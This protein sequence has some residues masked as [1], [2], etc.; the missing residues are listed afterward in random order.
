MLS[1]QLKQPYFFAFFCLVT[2]STFISVL[3]PLQKAE[4]VTASDWRAGRIIDDA[5]FYN[6]DSMSVAQIQD[7]LNAKVPTCDRWR[8]SS[9]P[10]YQ[11]PWT[12]LKEYLENPTTRENNVGRFNANGTPY[13]VPGGKSAAQI[14]WDVGQEYGINPQVLIVMLQK[15][16][17]LITDNWPWAVQYQ[18]AMGYA[19]PDTAPCDIQYYG[20]YNQVSSAAWQMKRYIAYPNSYNFKAGVTRNILWSPNAS[21]GASP[22]YIE[23]AATAALYNYTPYQPNAAALNNLYGTGDGCSAYGNRN[24]WRYFNDWFGSGKMPPAVQSINGGPIYLYMTGYRVEVTQMAI[25]QDYGISPESIAR[26]D[27]SIISSM[28]SP[29]TDGVSGQLG[30]IIKSTSD[31]DE[32]G[33]SIYFI[34]VGKKYQIKSMDQFFNFG[35]KE[36][37]IKYYP[38]SYINTISSAGYLSDFVSTPIYNVFK[39]SNGNKRLIFTYDDYVYYNPSKSATNISYFTMNRFT[40]GQPLVSKPALIKPDVGDT[41]FL[42]NQDAY[43]TIP[44]FDVYN[45]WGFEGNLNIPVYRVPSSSLVAQIQPTQT[46]QCLTRINNNPVLLNKYYAIPTGEANLGQE[47]Q[48]YVQLSNL[49]SRITI[50]QNGIKQ[51]VKKYDESLVW[52]LINGTKKAIPTYESFKLMGLTPNTVDVIYGDLLNT[53]PSG[54]PMLA[55]GQLV[56]T[57]SNSAV[58]VVFNDRRFIYPTSD[59]FISYGNNWNNIATI[60]NTILDTHYPVNN[61]SSIESMFYDSLSNNIYSITG[62]SCSILDDNLLDNLGINRSS[63]VA[64]Q[65]VNKTAFPYLDLNKCKPSSAYVKTNDSYLVYYLQNNTKYPILS[66]E[67]LLK[68]NGGSEPS[69]ATISNKYLENV[70]T[71]SPL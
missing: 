53:I 33:G 10:S 27:D 57:Q 9:N 24:F 8:A 4:A 59:L 46:L 22:V 14:I 5:V 11:P 21:C 36:T 13:Q 35:F 25:L 48:N 50:R 31:S 61:S 28:R 47:P 40:S 51:A 39:I 6:K 65:V 15:E 19:C 37:E 55:N 18:K 62:G 54:G 49:L 52:Y 16:Q 64:N 34:S 23:N 20:F 30:N 2:I 63:V 7:F 70:V 41:V 26:V 17:G 32:D 1:K 43:Y 66:Y 60:D 12:C 38:M 67:K 71:G 44:N 45:C 58:Y 29:S 68:N 69:I 42:Y 3:A 56:K